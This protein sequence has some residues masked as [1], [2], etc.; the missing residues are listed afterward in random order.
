MV[1]GE[2]PESPARAASS[3]LM[4]DWTHSSDTLSW[5]RSTSSVVEAWNG[6]VGPRDLG[7]RVVLRDGREIVDQHDLHGL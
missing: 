7:V 2:C 1:R 6:N 3:H 4:T 5:N